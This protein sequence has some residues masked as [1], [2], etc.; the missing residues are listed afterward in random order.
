MGPE[1]GVHGG[2]V[3]AQGTPEQVIASKKGYTGKYLQEVMG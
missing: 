1:G 3:V 2:Y